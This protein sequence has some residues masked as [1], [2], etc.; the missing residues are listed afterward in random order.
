[1][2]EYSDNFTALV[3][4]LSVPLTGSVE[5]LARHTNVIGA[6]PGEQLSLAFVRLGDD[7]AAREG[8]GDVAL[9]AALLG[10]EKV[11]PDDGRAA[12]GIA[13]ANLA[14]ARELGHVARSQNGRGQIRP[15]VQREIRAVA[16]QRQVLDPVERLLLALGNYLVGELEGGSHNLEQSRHCRYFVGDGFLFVIAWYDGCC[17]NKHWETLWDRLPLILYVPCDS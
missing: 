3:D 1:M 6:F 13:E 15:A 16:G 12:C 14:V 7:V 8:D 10:F 2:C 5:L 11:F 17:C 4:E 9:A